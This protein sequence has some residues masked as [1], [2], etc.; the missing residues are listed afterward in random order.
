MTI[1]LLM[2]IKGI[3]EMVT[4]VNDYKNL[5]SRIVVYN[6][7]D[8]VIV[9]EDIYNEKV[10]ENDF[11]KNDMHNNLYVLDSGMKV[12]SKTEGLAE[13][14]EIYSARFMGDYGY[15]LHIEIQTLFLQLIFLI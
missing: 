2:N 7:Q 5:V 6:K 8:E 4:T 3:L 1:Y 10:L 14:E 15:L 12:V 11:Y 13:N 9:Y